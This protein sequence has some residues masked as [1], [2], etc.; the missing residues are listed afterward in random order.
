MSNAPYTY[1]QIMQYNAVRSPSDI[2]SKN[3]ALT[4]YYESQLFNKVLSVFKWEG[5]PTTW[6]QNYF[7]QV[8]FGCG[9]VAVFDAGVYGVIPQNCTLSGL[10][11]FYQP[12]NAIIAN[13]LLQQ[14]KELEIG[15][16]CALIK[17]QPNYEGVWPIVSFYA[18]MLSLSAES[19][20]LN[21]VNTK[22]AYVFGATNKAQAES[23]KKMFDRVA[24]GEPAVVIDKDLLNDD[25]SRSW[26][27]FTQ[28]LSQNYIAG[29]ILNDMTTW[30]NKF[31]TEI[32]IPNANTQK[33]ERLIT[34]EVEAN[35]V[36]THTKAELWLD[37]IRL[38][39]AEVNK[40]FG[41]SITVDFREQPADEPEMA[42]EVE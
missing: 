39:L 19:A 1:A 15:K 21:L 4:N 7:L 37:N 17:L 11:I 13:P 28:N 36:D 34:S 35:N 2:H 22:L 38:G 12:K 32:G 5:I 26:E 20:A 18:D 8:L 16:D 6:A 30:E 29:D 27:T 9:Y 24:S 41:L 42:Q 23:F 14:Y 40:L 31:N 3:T 10:N 33:R 25:G